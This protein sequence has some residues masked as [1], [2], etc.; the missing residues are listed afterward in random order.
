VTGI[1]EYDIIA[2][3]RTDGQHDIWLVVSDGDQRLAG[4]VSRERAGALAVE[5]ATAQ[6]S[7]VWI[8][9][10]RADRAVADRCPVA[11]GC[12][13]GGVRRRSVSQRMSTGHLVPGSTPDQCDG[14]DL[15]PRCYPASS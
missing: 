13:G 10:S 11:R 9:S 8:A 3:R 15:L 5:F 1:Q 7:D 4:P 6:Q 2:R 12:G 14:R